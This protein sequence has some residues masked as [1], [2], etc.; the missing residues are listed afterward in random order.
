MNRRE[1][2]S[3]LALSLFFRN[4]VN[5]Q[6]AAKLNRIGFLGTGSSAAVAKPLEALRA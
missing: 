5:A 6:V 3:L 1:L 4:S 2:V